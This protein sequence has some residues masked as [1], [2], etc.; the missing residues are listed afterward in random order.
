[1]RGS[2]SGEP[3]GVAFVEQNKY[4]KVLSTVGEYRYNLCILKQ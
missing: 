2:D 4:K 3:T 1:M